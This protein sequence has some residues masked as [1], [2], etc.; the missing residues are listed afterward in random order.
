MAYAREIN[1]KRNYLQN[2]EKALIEM[3]ENRVNTLILLNKI[4]EMGKSKNF[5]KIII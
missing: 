4:R 3:R 1:N 5:K 2:V